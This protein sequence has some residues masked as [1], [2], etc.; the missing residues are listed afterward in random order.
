METPEQK[1]IREAYESIGMVW[2]QIK[3]L[4]TEMGCLVLP[5]PDLKSKLTG[6]NELVK[7][8]DKFSAFGR[9]GLKIMPRCL[10][11]LYNKNGWNKI[12]DE[13]RLPKESG[14]YFVLKNG[15]VD[16]GIYNKTYN[17][18]ICGGQ[19]YF[20]TLGDLSIT[21]YQ[22]IINPTPPIY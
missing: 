11:G 15:I 3:N 20:S 4:V 8:E 2:D 18:W 21:H 16:I 10:F 5:T 9:E 22:P 12:T 19:Y 1:A 17:K 13:E 14:K 7:Q 6:Y